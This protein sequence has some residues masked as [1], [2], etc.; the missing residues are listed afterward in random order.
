MMMKKKKQKKK[1]R[2]MDGD[3][4]RGRGLRERAPRVDYA[5]LDDGIDDDEKEEEDEDG[6]VSKWVEYVEKRSFGDASLLLQYLTS[7]AE[8]TLE[9][10][11][12]T[13]LKRPTVVKDSKGLGLMVPRKA[14]F[15]VRDVAKIVGENTPIEVINTADQSE[16][17]GWSLADWCNYWDGRRGKTLNVISLEFSRTKL[18]EQVRSP[19]IIRQLDWIDN[20]WP[21]QLRVR[22]EYP[23]TQY[24]CLM[25]PKGCYTDFHVDFGG[26]AV[27]YHVLRGRKIFYLSAPTAERL[28]LY[29]KWICSRDQDSV[30]FADLMPDSAT[31]ALTLNQGQTL[32]IPSAWLHAVYTP[33]DS[34]VFGGNF[35]PGLTTITDQLAVHGV[36]SRA[37]VANQFRFPFFTS[38]MFFG[39]SHTY[40][41][42]VASEKLTKLEKQG[43][44]ALIDACRVWS[45]SMVL[46]TSKERLDSSRSFRQKCEEHARLAATSVGLTDPSDLVEKTAALLQIE[47]AATTTSQKVQVKP[48][49]TL[50]LKL[51]QLKPSRDITSPTNEDHEVTQELTQ[52]ENDEEDDQ[53]DENSSISS[54]SDAEE[55]KNLKLKISTAWL[56]Q[57]EPPPQASI[58]THQEAHL[59][60][61]VKQE[62]QQPTKEKLPSKPTSSCIVDQSKKKK[63]GAPGGGGG[64]C[65]SAIGRLKNKL[66]KMKR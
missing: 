21:E 54:R 29:E 61:S 13:G 48:Q 35:L 59:T 5:A 1:K 20:A 4:M 7:G 36:E 58:P 28:T 49:V 31:V 18:S 65:N 64:N 11:R 44:S 33:E 16:V 23:Q 26:T 39:L 60:S 24:Y 46:S 32:I 14:D 12:R 38:A 19:T 57:A 6:K 15:N 66:A 3:K 43:L 63:R 51:S 37:R 10:A 55:V 47:L 42:L 52:N 25:S 27:W 8:L 41:R 9:W 40:R 56:E 17:A 2:K 22:G 34:L 62:E 30:F 50:K 53:Q 45:K